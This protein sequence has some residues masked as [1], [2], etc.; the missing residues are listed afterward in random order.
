MRM[1]H[2]AVAIKH[3]LVPVIAFCPIISA[4]ADT[5]HDAGDA[6]I[7]EGTLS[8][9]NKSIL[10]CGTSTCQTV[11]VTGE[12]NNETSSFYVKVHVKALSGTTV[13]YDK[14]TSITIYPNN[15]GFIISPLEFTRPS[16]DALV[17]WQAEC[18][19]SSIDSPNQIQMILYH[20]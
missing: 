19:I 5:I 17:F 14:S 2:I 16:F 20:R 8:S 10:L 1:K 6:P 4:F 3:C 13:L 12:S 7:M 18:S 15:S 9:S 11:Y